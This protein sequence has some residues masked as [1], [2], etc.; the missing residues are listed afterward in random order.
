MDN[1]LK[2]MILNT[3][4][5]TE[6]G[7]TRIKKNLEL[8]HYTDEQIRV[9]EIEIIQSTPLAHIETKGKNYY[10]KSHNYNIVL[11]INSHSF[12]SITAKKSSA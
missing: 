6:L 11:T 10:F 5:N 4:K 3:F 7:F 9:L 12:T 2:S 1:N 8:T